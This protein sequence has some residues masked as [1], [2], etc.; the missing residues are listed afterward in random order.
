MAKPHPTAEDI[1]TLQDR[2]QV[3]EERCGGL[4]IELRDARAELSGARTRIEALESSVRSIVMRFEG[5]VTGKSA[6]AAQSCHPDPT[7]A[8]E[9]DSP[10]V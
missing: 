1:E 3:L 7:S 5:P 9:G 4:S 6:P 8:P 2:C 10:P